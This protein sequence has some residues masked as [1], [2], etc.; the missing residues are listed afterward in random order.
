MQKLIVILLFGGLLGAVD[1]QP[2]FIKPLKE[3]VDIVSGFGNRYHPVLDIERLHSGVDYALEVGTE[4]VAAAPGKVTQT[5]R[6]STNGYIVIIEHKSGFETRYYHL[7]EPQEVEV[8]EKVDQ[9]ELIGYSG[10]TGMTEGAHL[11]FEIHKDGKAVD[12]AMYLVD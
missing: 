1:T 7:S 8:G 11:H 4:V 3:D 9:G 12:P 5:G 6:R 2:D 10:A